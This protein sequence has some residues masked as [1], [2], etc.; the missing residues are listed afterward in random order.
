MV[1]KVKQKSQ[2]NYFNLIAPQ[3]GES[4]TTEDFQATQS[5][6]QLGFNWP[7][8]YVSFL[9]SIKMDVD[10]LF[11]NPSRMSGSSGGGGY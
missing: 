8:D 7:Y 5:G 1:F 2:K 6:Y 4:S 3:A 9:E 11:H 10:V